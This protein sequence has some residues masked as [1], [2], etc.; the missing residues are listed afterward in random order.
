MSPRKKTQI[1]PARPSRATKV[2]AARTIKAATAPAS[3]RATRTT[4]TPT[5]PTAGTSTEPENRQLDPMLI[6]NLNTVT[7]MLPQLRAYEERFQQLDTSM[8][9][10]YHEL[11]NNMMGISND[12]S[13]KFAQLLHRLDGIG[14]SSPGRVTP[15]PNYGMPSAY[16]L[17]GNIP[18]A[19]LNVLSRWPWVDKDVVDSIGL[20]EFD[21][22]HL[23][24]L[25]REDAL[26]NRHIKSIKESYN[27]PLDGS[28]PELITGRTKMHQVFRDLPTFL[29]AWLIYSSI[30]ISFASERAPGLISWTERL[31]HKSLAGFSWSTIL[32][33]IIAYYIKHQKSAPDAW[34]NGDPEMIT[35]YFVLAP[36]RPAHAPISNN[37]PPFRGQS[38]PKRDTAPIQEQICQNWNRSILGCTIQDKTGH[39]CLRRHVCLLCQ[40]ETHK[41]SACP[42]RSS[43]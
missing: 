39:A 1:A 26:R 19:P 11:N 8:Q 17:T 38:Q 43:A 15:T 21:I 31:I 34:L 40:K 27:I 36:S 32:N 5:T 37:P 14:S 4:I 33:Y 3:R 28:K 12:L 35:D 13:E 7:E 20:G 30:R 24:K 22:Y 10:G 42:T 41:A 2:Q 23:P 25:H 16:T 29:S 9:T 18:D 6:E